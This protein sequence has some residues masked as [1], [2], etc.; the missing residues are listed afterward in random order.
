MWNFKPLKIQKIFYNCFKFSKLQ[1]FFTTYKW[2]I[3]SMMY[4]EKLEFR[5]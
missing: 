3:M 5:V 1:K 2:V 4:D